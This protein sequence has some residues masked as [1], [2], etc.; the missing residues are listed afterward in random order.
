M[1]HGL[2]LAPH[3]TQDG[4]AFVLYHRRATSSAHFDSSDRVDDARPGR[5][6]LAPR[7]CLQSSRVLN[8]ATLTT[9]EASAVGAKVQINP[10]P[11]AGADPQTYGQN[12]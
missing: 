4:A 3:Q 8:A 10:I 6:H 7:P 9:K 11:L 12:T 2:A 1:Q 5:Q